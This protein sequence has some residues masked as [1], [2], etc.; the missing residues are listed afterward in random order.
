MMGSD[1]YDR[2]K[3]IHKV[4]LKRF[5]MGKYP[6][7]QK[8]YKAVMGN[9][10]SHFQSD[11]NCP[12]EKV[13]WEDAK[14]F[15]KKLSGMTG[16]TVKLPSEAQWEYACRAG[17]NGKYYFGNDTN[18]LEKYAWYNKNSDNKTH[19][20]GQ[21][22]A[23]TWGLHDMHGNVWEWCEDLWHEN[24]NGAPT[25]G[26]AWLRGGEQNMRFLRGGSWDSGV[27]NCR[28]AGRDRI[29][30]GGRSSIIGFRVVI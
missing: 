20:V 23:N 29:S 18:Q 21:K 28:S 27:I 3:P 9:N 7:T 8:Q 25:D 2:E 5:R 12:V 16:Q 1:K 11:D 26:S 30:A 13:S 14:A 17:S 19:A 6:I 10:P 15:C 22:L 24:Y 4:T